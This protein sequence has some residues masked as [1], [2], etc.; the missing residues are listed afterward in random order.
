MS[1]N[2]GRTSPTRTYPS[3]LSRVAQPSSGAELHPP[4]EAAGGT[5]GASSG[6][7]PR[8]SR[9]KAGLPREP[10]SPAP[11]EPIPM[12]STAAPLRHCAAI[13]IAHDCGPE[14]RTGTLD[15]ERTKAQPPSSGWAFVVEAAGVEAAYYGAKLLPC[16][17]LPDV[18]HLLCHFWRLRHGELQRPENRV[19]TIRGTGISAK[20]MERVGVESTASSCC[21]AY[22]SLPAH[23][24]HFCEQPR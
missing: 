22:R 12:G 15:P 16:N 20:F 2:G 6:R 18:C 8:S 17:A 13:H 23:I 9:G 21:C 11:L 14:P 4:V 5:G 7:P 3:V 10:Y 24:F 1:H 19:G